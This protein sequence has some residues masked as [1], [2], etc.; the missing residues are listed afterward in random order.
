MVF[1]RVLKL[2]C[3]LIISKLILDLTNCPWFS[4]PVYSSCINFLGK[5]AINI[6]RL[7]VTYSIRFLLTKIHIIDTTQVISTTSKQYRWACLR[8]YQQTAKSFPGKKM[9][10]YIK[11]TLCTNHILQYGDGWLKCKIHLKHYEHLILINLKQVNAW[12]TQY[13]NIENM[14]WSS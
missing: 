11:E 10:E 2:Y 14:G 9:I 3:L 4:F 8:V 12:E 13:V 5:L 1:T 7:Q 6:R